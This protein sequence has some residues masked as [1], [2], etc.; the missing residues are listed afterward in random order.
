MA[1]YLQAGPGLVYI[2]VGV[3]VE[4]LNNTKLTYN[5]SS[6]SSVARTLGVGAAF[7]TAC[8]QVVHAPFASQPTQKQCR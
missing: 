3:D 2:H 1:V 7:L 6:L 4:A 5:I 8:I